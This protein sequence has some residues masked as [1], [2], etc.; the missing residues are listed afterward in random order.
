MSSRISFS[1]HVIGS[2]LTCDFII[3]L[4]SVLNMVLLTPLVGLTHCADLWS[5]VRGCRPLLLHMRGTGRV[6]WVLLGSHAA[7]EEESKRLELKMGFG[8][9]AICPDFGNT[10]FHVHARRALTRE[11]AS[12]I[13]GFIVHVRG[14]FVCSSL[15]PPS[16]LQGLVASYRPFLS[17]HLS[18]M[19]LLQFSMT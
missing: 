17:P 4:G 5:Q 19:N 1:C 9:G 8:V 15:C 7:G 16:G 11:T 10:C 12:K 13:V 3:Q 14:R 6:R 18:A 2:R